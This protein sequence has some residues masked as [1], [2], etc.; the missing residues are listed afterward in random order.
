[1]DLTSLNEERSVLLQ[2]IF[3]LEAEKKQVKNS[4]E[5]RLQIS[6]ELVHFR[7]QLSHVQTKIIKLILNN[8]TRALFAFILT[9]YSYTI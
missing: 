8:Q 6:T 4:T 3:R 9:C 2:R 1:M 5:K 7:K